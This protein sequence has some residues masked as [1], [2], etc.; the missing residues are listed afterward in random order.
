MKRKDL[1][2]KQLNSKQNSNTHYLMVGEKKQGQVVTINK[3]TGSYRN[4]K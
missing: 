2:N 4:R 1:L 3:G